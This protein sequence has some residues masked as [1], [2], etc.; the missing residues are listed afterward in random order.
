[1]Y[2]NS[3]K[4]ITIG[5]LAHVDAGK[6]TLSESLLYLCGA[7]RQAGRV[8]H[9][10]TFLDTAE[11]ERERGIT[12]FSKQAELTCGDTEVILLDTPGHVDFSAEM[13][14]VLSVLDYAVLVV[15]GREGV[16]GHTVTLWKLLETYNIPTFI[17]VNKM[18]MDGAYPDTILDDLRENL[19][20]NITRRDD[21]EQIA[22]CE[23]GLLDEYIENDR[24]DDTSIAEAIRRRSFCPVFFG[25]ALKMDGVDELIKA[26]DE[27]TIE[28]PSKVDFGAKV[29]K[30]TRDAKGER[31]THMKLTGGSLSVREN[32]EQI[33][34][35]VS[36]IRIYSGDKF[37]TV[38]TAETGR[39]V[40]V[41]GLNGTWA[42]QG[43]GC[44]ADA[45]EAV[46]EP[47]LSYGIILPEGVNV[48]EFLTKLRTIE[49]EDPMLSVQWSEQ[50][51]EVQLRLMG[52]VQLDI[53]RTQIRERTGVSCE[54]TDGRIAYR[55]T[56]TDSVY[57]YGHFEPLRHYAEVALRIDPLPKGSGVE[58][59]TEA[60]ED[61]FDLNW[62]RLVLTHF[63]EKEHIG[64]LA[65]FPITDVRLVLLDGRAHKKHT[66]GGDFRQATY[67]G[68]RQALRTAAAEGKAE[69]L[70]PWYEFSLSVP[71][72]FIG[73][74]MT[75]VRRM[76]GE[77]EP[78]VTSVA[79]ISKLNGRAP[80]SEM[81]SY[82]K[83]LAAF[84][85]GYG[86]IALRSAGYDVCHNSAEVISE[87][88]YDA[89]RDIENTADSVFCSHGAGVNVAWDEVP[90]YVH[91]EPV[92]NKPAAAE[93]PTGSRVAGSQN[94]KSEDETLKEIFERTYGPEKKKSGGAA[95]VRP[96]KNV[97]P[98]K[99]FE[100]LP[101]Y[102]LVDGY[103]V[104]FAWEELRELAK[105]NIDSAREALIEILC[106]YRGTIDSEIIVVFD[107]YRVSGG[108]RRNEMQRNIRVVYTGEAESA[109]A[110]IERETFEIKK[111]KYRVRV[112]TKD[113]AEQI[114][115]M[116]NNATAVSPE[117]FRREIDSAE[118]ATR[119]WLEDYKMKLRL[120]S[121]NTIE[122]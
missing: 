86:T 20:E 13:E 53:I 76:S 93:A 51:Q 64:T 97:K 27:L 115:V 106:N 69:L 119:E 92:K 32:I 31:L 63:A 89:D 26:I 95:F 80:V 110:F 24:I 103:N 18:D 121:R 111:Q 68:I 71:S 104:I 45:H 5:I 60:D 39:I 15:S 54:F 75:D 118:E 91:I 47:V 52:E 30:I 94:N 109:D 72:E 61:S 113:V 77:F 79:G 46:L 48:S 21:Y 87:I 66:E 42:G 107:A 22:M 23:A 85:K 4:R 99:P 29:F 102:I 100:L 1:M 82:A 50:L 25:S 73:R 96:T 38:E 88:G 19:S 81:R 37:R 83:E 33:G 120:R 35:K 62:Q 114:I 2:M 16:Q 49:E 44:E 108:E 28:E 112:V 116:S 65:G 17:W 105:S 74:A 14:R 43:L 101:E 7:I 98:T 8:D 58:F 11:L 122:L 12:I 41:T 6:T 67:R 34:E 57:G 36:Q 3:C 117:A 55:E 9:K 78:P 70:E 90:L 59:A 84:T 10:D 56:V 40:Q